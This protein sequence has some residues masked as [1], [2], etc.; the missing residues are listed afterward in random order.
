MLLHLRTWIVRAVPKTME[1]LRLCSVPLVWAEEEPLCI[2]TWSLWTFACE[3]VTHGLSWLE[4][5]KFAHSFVNS[6]NMGMDEWDTLFIVH[7]SHL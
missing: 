1:G 2:R 6:R 5:T 3:H 4:C 7:S